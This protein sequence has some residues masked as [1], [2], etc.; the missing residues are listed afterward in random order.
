[1]E[2]VV[3]KFESEPERRKSE[4]DQVLYFQGGQQ[5]RLVQQGQ[6]VPELPPFQVK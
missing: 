4:K 3:Q 6:H 1:M 2:F 5:H